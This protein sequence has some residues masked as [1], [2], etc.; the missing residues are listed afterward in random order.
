MTRVGARR[1]RPLACS[2]MDAQGEKT[3]KSLDKTYSAAAIKANTRVLQY[4]YACGA[5]RRGGRKRAKGGGIARR[6]PRR[7]ARA[8][9]LA[10][11]F[12]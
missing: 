9:R 7:A 1:P 10:V 11:P 2:P 3:L 12:H 6:P 8:L 4:W 5:R